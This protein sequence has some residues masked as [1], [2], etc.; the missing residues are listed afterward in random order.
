MIEIQYNDMFDEI[1]YQY[2]IHIRFKVLLNK[3]DFEEVSR[4][5]SAIRVSYSLDQ[6][7]PDRRL[8]KDNV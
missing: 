6:I 2:N 3:N 4:E 7:M 1:K 8:A 5:F